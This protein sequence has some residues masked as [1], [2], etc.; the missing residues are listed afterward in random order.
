MKTLTTKSGG[1]LIATLLFAT[2]PTAVFADSGFYVGVGAGGATLEASLDD[3]TLPGIPSSIDE[4]DTATKIFAGYNFA[5]PVIDVGVEVAYTD[6]GEPEVDI[7]GDRLTLDTTG[8]SLWGIA[9]LDVGPAQIF[10]KLGY[11]DWDVDADFLNASSS[12]DG[13]DIGYGAGVRFDIGPLEVRG[14]YEIYDLEDT[15][16]A[17]LSVGL[18]YYFN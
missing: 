10:G 12:A 11:I 2:A 6:F 18:A 5:L 7:A 17:M 3:V 8:L 4:D 16:L 14:E 9:A 1:T 15:D 13:S